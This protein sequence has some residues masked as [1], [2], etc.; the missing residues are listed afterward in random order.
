MSYVDVLNMM[1]YNN[2]L[3]KSCYCRGPPDGYDCVYPN[4]VDNNNES[5]GGRLQL[6]KCQYSRTDHFLASTGGGN[7]A[8]GVVAS[9]V[10]ASGV[11]A[12]CVV[13]SGVVASASV[14]TA[15][16]VSATVVVVGVGVVSGIAAG[17]VAV[18]RKTHYAHTV[19]NYK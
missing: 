18:D 10:V 7:V 6:I 4:Q 2:I 9:G 14:V 13:A 5:C 15:T 12:S 17:M 3:Q 11:V 16:V 19:S 8:G 1:S